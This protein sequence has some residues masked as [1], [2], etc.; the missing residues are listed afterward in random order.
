[1]PEIGDS[2]P[3]PG[4]YTFYKPRECYT[5][6]GDKKVAYRKKK[7]AKIARRLASKK[8]EMPEILEYDVYRCYVCKHYHLGSK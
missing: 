5:S 3:D 7:D 6:N 8:Y 1:M 2:R 4:G